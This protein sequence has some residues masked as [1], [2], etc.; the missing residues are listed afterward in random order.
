MNHPAAAAAFLADPERVTWH[1]GAV[2]AVRAKRDTQAHGVP[3]WEALREA[4]EAWL[5]PQME[6]ALGRPPRMDELAA[7]VR[8]MLSPVSAADVSRFRRTAAGHGE[9]QRVLESLGMDDPIPA[10]AVC[11]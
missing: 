7:E 5:A 4:A 10:E 6:L 8:S 9:A 11:R 2:W 1:D 3:E